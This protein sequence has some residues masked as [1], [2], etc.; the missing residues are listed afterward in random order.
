MSQ[1]AQFALLGLGIAAVYT[2]LAQGIVLTYRGSGVVNLAQGSFAMIGAFLYYQLRNSH[3]FAF[4]P[5]FAVAVIAVAVIGAV[6][7]LCVMRPLRRATPVARLIATLGV[8]IVLQAVGLL[9]FGSSTVLVTSSLPQNVYHVDGIFV[10]EDRLILLGIALALT[11][12]LWA[13]SRYSLFGL[14]SRAVAE[15]ERAAAGLAWSPDRIATVNWAFGGALAAT[16]GILVVPLTGLQAITLTLIVIGALAAALIGGFSSF[17]MTLIGGLII[18]IAQSELTHY[19]SQQG[20]SDTLPLLVIIAVLMLR[21]KVLP[22]R[23]VAADRLPLLGSAMPRLSVIAPCTVALVVLIFVF[24]GSWDTAIANTII[25]AVML[26]SVVVLTGYTGQ[27]SLAQYALGGMGAF[28]TG[29]FIASEGWPDWAAIL[30]GVAFAVAIGI[31]FGLPALRTRGVNLAVLTLGLGLA[32]QSLVFNNAQYT[33]GILGTN[34]GALHIFGIDLDPIVYPDRFA[35]FVFLVFGVCALAISNIRRSRVGRRMIAV[36][37]NERAAASLGI[38]VVGAKLYAFGLSSGLAGLSGILLGLSAYTIVF[39]NYDPVSSIYAVALSVIGGVGYISGALFG[40][41]LSSNGIGNLIGNSIFG[42]NVGN[43]LTLVGGLTLL[44]LLIRDPDGIASANAKSLSRALEKLRKRLPVR[45]ALVAK[46]RTDSLAAV[47]EGQFR[48]KPRELSVTGATVR[49]GGVQALTGVSV[50]IGSGEVV[51]VI[52]PNGAGKTTLIDA[53]T[54]FVGTADGEVRVD[55]VSIEGWSPSRRA[56]LGMTRSFQSLELFEDLTVRENLLAGSDSRDLRAYVSNLVWPGK[57]TLP[58]AALAAVREF[59]LLDDLDRMAAELPFGRRRLVGIAR[60]IATGASLI[61]LDEPGAGLDDLERVE[62]AQVIRHMAGEWGMSVMLVEHDMS[63]VMSTCDRIL[64]LE[65]GR[66]LAEGTPEVIRRD[67]RVVAVYLGDL[68]E[69]V[70]Q[71][72]S[73]SESRA[74]QPA[75][76]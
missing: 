7:H 8:L 57:R 9:Y 1:F 69:E 33:G 56:R 5:A 24:P 39:T 17:P 42:T 45:S 74:A 73:R 19:W 36:R 68:D 38:N 16:A 65:A 59:D 29:K 3:G 46:E 58:S 12:L 10:T 61:L 34:V 41:T 54:G 60:A 48:V 11:V 37:S 35:V 32:L 22:V 6:T 26:L 44:V 15:N 71:P 76:R 30:I 23:G 28:V 53:I 4:L 50:S 27:V 55:G 20:V 43:W 75:E 40:S 52:G 66:L 49:F 63:L 2:L 62:L 47:P 51:G 70:E 14:A 13:V 72:S 25:I 21:G 18:G 31:L 67:D 64:V